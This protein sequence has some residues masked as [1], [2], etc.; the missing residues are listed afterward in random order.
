MRTG[1]LAEKLGMTRVFDDDGSHVPVSVL[2]VE[3]CEVVAARRPD[4]DGYAAVQLGIGRAKAKNVT[5]PM[6]GHFA[7]AKVTPKARLAE[8]RVSEDALLEPGTSLSVGHFVVGQYVDVCGTSIGKGF[9]G[10]MK[11]WGFKGLRASHGVSLSHRSHGSTGNRQ[12]PGKVFKGKKMAGHMGDRRVTVQNLEVVG[13]DHER[14]L[15]LVKGAV[16]GARGGYVRVTD[17]IKRALPQEA[18]YPAGVVTTGAPIGCRRWR[19]RSRRGEAAE[20]AG[21]RGVRPVQVSVTTLDRQD[22]GTI[23]LNPAVFGQPL[24][25]DILHQVVRW[26]LAKRRQGTHKAKTRGEVNKTT[27]KMYKQKGTGRAR[28]GAAS[29][30]QFRGGGKPFGPQAARPCHRSAQEGA[31][32]GPQDRAVQQARRGQARGARPGD[33]G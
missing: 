15:I 14:G 23:E 16:P 13:I 1:V 8:F 20:S 7:K 32:A 19:P 5:K 26:Q 22:A 9:A 33:P 25:S 17:A 30:P 10:A 11:R 28:H 3:D 29:A 18:P 31:P 21:R 2:R 6:R 27:R 12:D 4:K 24:R